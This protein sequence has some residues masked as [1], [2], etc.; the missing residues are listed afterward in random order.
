M[1]AKKSPEEKL[2]EDVYF[3]I[4]GMTV[5]QFINEGACLQAR[6]DVIAAALREQGA[7]VVSEEELQNIA[8]GFMHDEKLKEYIEDQMGWTAA[9]YAF[10]AGFK[11]GRG[12]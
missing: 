8:N 9:K 6:I 3:K 7:P 11:S 5:S 1:N 12:E 4:I 2:A 10:K